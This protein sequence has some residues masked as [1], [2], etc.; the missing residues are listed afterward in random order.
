MQ[1][2]IGKSKSLRVMLVDDSDTDLFINE[3]MIKYANFSD[4]IISFSSSSKAM[5]YLRQFSNTPDASEIP[6]VIFLDINMPL[7]SGF[8]FIREYQSFPA[9]MKEKCHI[10]LLSS[11][12][13][14]QDIQNGSDNK[15]VI[16]LIAKPLTIEVLNEM[17]G[18]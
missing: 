1:W 2:N 14:V 15:E 3:A 7:M 13:N 11:T 16:G 5:D 8:E 10:V 4:D 6:D 9:K 18:K 12:F 17:I